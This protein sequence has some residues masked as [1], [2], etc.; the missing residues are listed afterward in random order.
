MYRYNYGFRHLWI[1][2]SF[3]IL[4][5]LG[6]SFAAAPGRAAQTVNWT[7]NFAPCSRHSELFKYGP[8]SLGVKFSTSNRAIEREFKKAMDFWSGVIEMEWHEDDSSACSIN[9][10][11]GT[12]DILT[13]SVI[14]RSQFPEWENFEGWIAFDPHAPLSKFEMYVTAVHEIGHMLG[15]KHNPSASSIM[16]FLDL[17]GP[18]VLDNRDLVSLAEHHQLSMST[19]AGPI[20]VSKHPSFVR[21]KSRQSASPH[22]DTEPPSTALIK[23]PRPSEP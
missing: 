3:C 18:E 7:G 8:M 1:V 13:N 16:Y 9:V 12:P 21:A 19:L 11:D 23:Q 5:I 17:E 10:V 22:P 2:R 6:L 20:A 15:L 4:G 14:A